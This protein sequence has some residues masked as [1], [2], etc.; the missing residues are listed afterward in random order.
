M[1]TEKIT[2]LV[3]LIVIAI[4]WY[5][6]LHLPGQV[7]LDKAYNDL[8][9][10]NQKLVNYQLALKYF[11]TGVKKHNPDYSDSINKKHHFAGSDEVVALYKSLDS[12]CNRPE[13]KLEEITPSLEEMIEYQRQRQKGNSTAPVPIRLKLDGRFE[14]LAEL[15]A[16][17]E[18][19]PHF[20]HWLTTQIMGSKTMYPS[21]KLHVAFVARLDYAMEVAGI[22]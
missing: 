15:I 11:A 22:E 8:K 18:N 21:C 1:R 20:D 10:A 3:I 16:K 2:A 19:H 14:R 17:I 12:L 13:F 7:R 5:L 9:S 4:G 6:F